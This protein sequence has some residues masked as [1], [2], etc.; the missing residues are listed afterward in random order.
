VSTLEA[1]K[2]STDG[3]EGD[4]T[5]EKLSSLCSLETRR[6]SSICCDLNDSMELLK[7]GFLVLLLAEST[8]C[9][10]FFLL[11]DTNIQALPL[12]K[13]VASYFLQ[14]PPVIASEL[15]WGFN[16]KTV[17]ITHFVVLS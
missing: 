5:G 17:K 2:Y 1:V 9:I 6:S 10:V 7:L 13:G 16:C 3:D 8:G 12:L 14:S 11:V 4:P 15:V